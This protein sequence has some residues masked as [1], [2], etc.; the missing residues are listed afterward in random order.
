[1]TA[2]KERKKCRLVL[3]RCNESHYSINIPPPEET[4]MGYQSAVYEV[5]GARLN[6]NLSADAVSDFP[7]NI[8]AK[9]VWAAALMAKELN[10][11]YVKREGRYDIVEWEDDSGNKRSTHELINISNRLA[12]MGLIYYHSSHLKDYLEAAETLIGELQLDFMFKI[13]SDDANGYE[14]GI[15]KVIGKETLRTNDFGV[16]AFAPYYY[17][18]IKAA[19]VM[20]GRIAESR[21]IANVGDDVNLALENI[22]VTPSN[23]DYGGWNVTAIT[24]NGCLV[25]F[26]TS[27]VAFTNLDG[28]YGVKAKVKSHQ[29]D[30]KTQITAETR[31]NYVKII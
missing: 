29:M 17:E 22:R 12:M 1:M 6:L 13:L 9:L 14:D 21:H 26:F 27:K 30:W 23:G 18:N 4:Q 25:S 3:D 5:N 24:D 15:A 10:G 28:W 31:L 16:I 8:T 2:Q 19:R 7:E 11:A 20:E